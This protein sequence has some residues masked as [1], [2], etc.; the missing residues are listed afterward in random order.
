MIALVHRAP[1]AQLDRASAFE[2]EGREFESLRARHLHMFSVYILRSRTTG[3]YYTGS[4]SDLRR[5]LDR[6]NAGQSASTKNRGPWDLVHHE[7]YQSLAEAVRRERYFKTG[8]GRDELKK[9]ASQ[10]SSAG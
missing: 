9:L 6:H 2:A 4:T 1:V 7:E 10:L 8:K 5:R 3:R